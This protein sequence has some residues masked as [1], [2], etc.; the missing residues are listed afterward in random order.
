M[1]RVLR[2][3]ALVLACGA[4]GTGFVVAAEAGVSDPPGL[5][6]TPPGQEPCDHGLGG[7][8]GNAGPCREDPQPERGKDCDA[9]G[10]VG[11]KNEDHCDGGEGDGGGWIG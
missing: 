1:R 10:N 2:F 6:G 7:T 9:H 11:G 3:A 5:G 8:N 4:L